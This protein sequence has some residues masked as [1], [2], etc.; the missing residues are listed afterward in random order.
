MFKVLRAF[1]L[2]PDTCQWICTFY[3]DIKSSVTVN[4]QL[5]QWFAIKRGCRQEDPISPY[6]FI[7]CVEIIAIMIR[8]NKH[9]KGIMKLNKK[10]FHNMQMILKLRWKVT[11]FHLKKQLRPSTHSEKHQVSS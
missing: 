7:L 3:K 5:S 10:I 1:A 11:K 6:L 2:G 4:G 9:I 8:Q